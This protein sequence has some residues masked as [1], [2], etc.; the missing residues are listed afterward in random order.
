MVNL[1][2]RLK[3]KVKERLFSNRV[4]Y[5]ISVDSIVKDLKSVNFYTDLKMST[6]HLL[7]TF[8]QTDPKDQ[9]ELKWGECFFLNITKIN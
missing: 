3:P 5:K 4:K 9:W 1:Y 8:S 2:T 6:I 7:M